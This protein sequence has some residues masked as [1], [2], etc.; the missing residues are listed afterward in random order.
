M[1]NLRTQI[2]LLERQLKAMENPEEIVK[3]IEGT[4]DPKHTINLLLLSPSYDS[5]SAILFWAYLAI[6][7]VVESAKILRDCNWLHPKD[8][9]LEL[10]LGNFYFSAL[11]NAK[12]WGLELDFLELEME[13]K[14]E[15]ITLD[16]LGLSFEVAR[17]ATER[18]FL[19]AIRLSTDAKFKQQASAAL[20]TLRMME[21][22]VWPTRDK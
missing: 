8:A 13:L 12:G 11:C 10:A 5:N 4:K 3:L 21:R 19:N 20:A 7:Q 14:L 1:Q 2:P 22:D 16:A 9:Q 6:G 17:D 15:Q 18:L